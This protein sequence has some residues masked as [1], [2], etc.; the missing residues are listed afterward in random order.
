MTKKTYDIIIAP[1]PV[2]KTESKA[3]ENVSQDI[4][5]QIDM[6]VETMYDGN[7]IGLAANQVGI[8]NRVFVMDVPLGIWEYKGED[9]HGILKIGS[10]YKSGNRDEEPAPNPIHM[11]N[12][13]IIW[14]SEERSV[15]DEGCLSL[16][17][18]YA[19][20]ER[21]A[22]VR[23]KY[24]DREGKEQEQEFAGLDSH[25]AQHELDHLDGILFVDHI[26]RLKRN[27]I[28]RKVEKAKKAQM[29]L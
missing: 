10:A 8:T 27:T 7:G 4:K 26:S 19:K 12:P 16:P 21:P 25:C 18:Q 29:L 11:V 14:R 24:L 23:I 22:K 1:D 13:E 5:S 2:L 9:R 17:G 20:V 6:M 3:V 15:Y 28:L